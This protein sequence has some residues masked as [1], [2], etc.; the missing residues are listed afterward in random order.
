MLE[1]IS[2]AIDSFNTKQGDIT[3][4]LILPLSF[5][6]IYEVILRYVFNAPT[7]WGFEL[8]IFLYGLHFMFG[9]PYTDV[10]G[11]NVKVDVFTSRMSEKK[12]A[13][14]NI[15]TTSVFFLPV[16]ICLTIFTFKFAYISTL[17]REVN[18]TSWAPTIWPY[19]IIVAFC[20]LLLLL[21]G[22]SNL[23]KSIR[24]LVGQTDQITKG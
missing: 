23:L 12:Q 19:K 16:F 6:V 1:K 21:Q 13:I 7:I 3:S 8:T 2:K 10:L 17:Q 24:V 22:V 14:L 9:Y 5:V 20:F 15:I 11:G 4:L 18:S